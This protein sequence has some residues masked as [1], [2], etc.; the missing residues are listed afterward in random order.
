MAK[1]EVILTKHIVGLGSE[2]DQIKVAAG[3]ARNYL[4]PQGYAVTLT[5]ANKRQ[6]EA[7][8]QR[9]AEREAHE[10]NS[11]NDLAKSISKLTAVL[12]VK[13]GDDGKLFGSVTPGMIADELKSHFD[14]SLDRK[15]IHVE[16]PIRTL[17]EHEVVL[18]LHADISSTLKVRVESLNPLPAPE[19]ADQWGKEKMG[20]KDREGRREGRGRDRDRG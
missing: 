3:Y 2:S 7:L 18:K 1:T 16:T 11:M 12:K 19:P 8:R 9:R 17:G 6:L 5:A 13:T 15:K 20:G 4:I 10:F 14:I